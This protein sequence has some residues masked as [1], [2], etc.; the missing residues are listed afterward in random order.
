MVQIP[1]RGA[2]ADGVFGQHSSAPLYEHERRGNAAARSLWGCQ[3]PGFP[4]RGEPRRPAPHVLAGAAAALRLPQQRESATM[5]LLRSCCGLW[6]LTP[7]VPATMTTG[8]VGPRHQH[9]APGQRGIHRM[10][11]RDL[12]PDRDGAESL[13]ARVSPRQDINALFSSSGARSRWLNP[14]LPL[15]AGRRRSAARWRSSVSRSGAR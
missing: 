7:D 14:E 1:D 13:D 9:P 4:L 11:W 3:E 6:P 15:R 8:D 12:Q 10:C 5:F 2:L